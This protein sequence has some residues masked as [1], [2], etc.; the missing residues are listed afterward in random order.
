M[1]LRPIR[2]TLTFLQPRSR[3]VRFRRTTQSARE[4]ASVGRRSTSEEDTSTRQARRANYPVITRGSR[5]PL[6]LCAHGA[7]GCRCVAKFVCSPGERVWEQGSRHAS[8]AGEESLLDRADG[9]SRTTKKT[10]DKRAPRYSGY[11]PVAGRI[12][13]TLQ[14]ARIRLPEGRFSF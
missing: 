4:V 3:R 8:A 13:A 2:G 11:P 7:D 6:F 14:K 5:F 1:F 9:R 10:T 12:K